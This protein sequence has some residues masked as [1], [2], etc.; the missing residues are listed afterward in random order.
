LA[1][2][3]VAV[4]RFR[5]VLHGTDA[6]PASLLLGALAA[7][8]G[9]MAYLIGTN[10]FSLH[11]MY[12][13]RLIRAYLGA[14]HGSGGEPDSELPDAGARDD[15]SKGRKPHRFTGFDPDDNVELANL[16]TCRPFLVINAALNLV[17]PSGERLEWQQRK[18]ASF[19]FTPLMC[20]SP[21]LGYAP[22]DRYARKRPAV[23]VRDQTARH[24][25]TE[26]A[27]P[28]AGSLS[29]G[30][31]MA[32]SG[33][34]ASPNMGYHSSV[35]VA[36]VMSFFNV[37]L[38]WW[39]PNTRVPPGKDATESWARDE[40]PAAK[41]LLAETL[42]RTTEDSEFV[43]LSDGGHF[44]NLGLYEM[45]RRRCRRI[46]V[47]DATRDAEFNHEDLLSSLRKIRIDF[48]ISIDFPRG[49]PTAASCAAHGQ[50][51]AVGQVHYA[52]ADAG[53]RAGVIVYLKPAIW[54]GLPP[55]VLRYAATSVKRG[56][57]FPHQS[58]ADQFF[59][60]A[61]FESYRVLGLLTVIKAFGESGGWP[62][63]PGPDHREGAGRGPASLE[64]AGKRRL[65]RLAASISRAVSLGRDRSTGVA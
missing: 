53:A 25:G 1:T 14:S 21:V 6:V 65:G 52:D 40:P 56:T 30:R 41:T 62:T 59:D 5:G 29:V 28:R 39:L 36:F 38:G 26:D 22:T 10:T 63:G 46:V 45:V 50:P 35:V 60:E 55:D 51:W 61:Q 4:A 57:P 34:A 43:Y 18:A 3:A 9:L 54:K 64:A 23:D 12:G 11:S 20:G 37:R 32:I 7:L 58:T 17:Q 48:G 31:A 13:N 19:T 47:V 27:D 33:A 42:A 2:T 8:A 44:E 15:P 24:A 49:L 16:A